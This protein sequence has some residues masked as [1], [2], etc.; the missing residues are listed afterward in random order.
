MIPGDRVVLRA[1]DAFVGTVEKITD[2]GMIKVKGDGWSGTLPVD[3]LVPAATA[4]A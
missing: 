3:A 1:S 2:S 4:D